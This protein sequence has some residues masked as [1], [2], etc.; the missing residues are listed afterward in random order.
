[1]HDTDRDPIRRLIPGT[2]G[3]KGTLAKLLY[4][5]ARLSLP[6]NLLLFGDKMSM[7]NS[8]EMRV[9][10]L[11]LELMRFLEALPTSLKLRGKTGKYL[12]K[13]ALR[14]WLPPEIIARKKRGFAT[15]MDRWLQKELV[16]SA[17]RLLNAPG[18]AT[19]R[20]FRLEGVNEMLAKHQ[21]RRE[22][23]RR[24]IFALLCFE[25]WHQVILEGK[26]APAE[27]FI[28]E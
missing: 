3:L 9:P 2:G 21:G 24:H 25:L 18:S 7:A 1:M 16:D 11:D 6:D 20:Y 19:G 8:L 26:T 4:L 23:Y 27:L 14:R 15:P 13:K 5:D 28:E 12:H 10:F 22:N 17:R